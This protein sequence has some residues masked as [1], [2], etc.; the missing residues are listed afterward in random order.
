MTDGGYYSK[1]PDNIPLIGQSGPGLYTCV[2]LSGYG[3]MASCAAGDLA[4]KHVTGADLPS[5]SKECLSLKTKPGSAGNVLG[6]GSS[7]TRAPH[8]WVLVVRARADEQTKSNWRP[9]MGY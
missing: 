8:A 4:A 6:V 3:I 9:L 2:G 5:K 1:A 7:S